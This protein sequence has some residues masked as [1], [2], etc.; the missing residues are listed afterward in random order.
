LVQIIIHNILS[1]AV[2]YSAE[3]STV[4]VSVV[5]VDGHVNISVKDMGV[6]IPQKEQERVFTRLF[7]ASN[8]R[9]VDTTG[10]GLGLYISRMIMNQ[11]GGKIRFKS[12]EK[13]GSVFIIQ[14]PLHP[15]K[16]Q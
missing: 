10:S 14:L 7:R 8:V 5:R 3:G 2:K 11:L 1:N 4:T 15:R 13:S 6:G 16:K 9:K 12:R